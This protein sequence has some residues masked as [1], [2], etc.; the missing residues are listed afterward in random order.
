LEDGW[1]LRELVQVQ[2]RSQSEVAL[3]L[4]RSI[5][6]VNRRLALVRVLPEAVQ[7]AV[8]R[9]QIPAHA[10]M[11]VLIPLARAK[12]VHAARFLERLEGRRVSVRQM[13]AF[14]HAYKQTDDE[15]RQRLVDHPW[16]FFKTREE[17]PQTEAIEPGDTTRLVQELESLCGLARRVRR[18]IGAGVY[19]RAGTRS[20]QSIEFLW[21]ECETAL[22]SLSHAMNKECRDVGSRPAGGDPTPA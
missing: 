12:A 2:G 5:S 7:D 14:Y 4:Q 19:K 6:W 1:L 21:A 17:S 18:R 20:R 8:R 16:L 11:R 10:A 22:A 3:A 9:A 15:G 13:D